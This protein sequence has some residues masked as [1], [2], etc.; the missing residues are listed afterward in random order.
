MRWFD[1]G[2]GKAKADS[3][4]QRVILIGFLF[5]VAVPLNE[6]KRS[7]QRMHR[8]THLRLTIAEFDNTFQ[9]AIFVMHSIQH[10]TR[11]LSFASLNIFSQVFRPEKI[12]ESYPKAYFYSS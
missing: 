5:F 7:P 1:S 10:L 3:Q 2:I 6:N 4:Q 12:L 9:L 11:N 8:P